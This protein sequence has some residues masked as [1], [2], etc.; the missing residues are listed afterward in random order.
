LAALPPRRGGPKELKRESA[1]AAHIRSL[2]DRGKLSEAIVASEA[3]IAADP[4][5]PEFHYLRAIALLAQ[6]RKE[7]AFETLR[8]VIYLDRT[9]AIAHFAMGTLL[10]RRGEVP[11]ARRAFQ[12]AYLLCTTNDPNEILPL[13]D[14]E[15]TEGLAEAA[16]AH[17]EML[18]NENEGLRVT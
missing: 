3:A 1:P 15:R 2:A 16:L 4:T 6:D 12:R 11:K 17:I 5:A 14:G 18:N 10:V 13:S 8:R 9:L 7:E